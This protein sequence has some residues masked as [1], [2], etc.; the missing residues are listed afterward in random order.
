MKIKSV[1]PYAVEV[2]GLGIYAE[3]GQAVEVDD[4][5]AKHLLK[6]GAWHGPARARRRVE[7]S[8]EPEPKSRTAAKEK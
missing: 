7:V 8:A 5:D 3:P 2:A 6:S 1:L 4:A